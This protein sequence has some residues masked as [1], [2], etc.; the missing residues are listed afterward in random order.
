MIAQARINFSEDDDFQAEQLEFWFIWVNLIECDSIFKNS[1]PLLWFDVDE[2]P[3]VVLAVFAGNSSSV[4][5][6]GLRELLHVIKLL[7]EIK[8]LLRLVEEDLDLLSH[9]DFALSI[10][11]QLHEQTLRILAIDSWFDPSVVVGQFESF[12]VPKPVVIKDWV[13]VVT[14]HYLWQDIGIKVDRI[15]VSVHFSFF[16][17]I[18]DIFLPILLLRIDLILLHKHIAEVPVKL[19][20]TLS[21]SRTCNH[22]RMILVLRRLWDEPSVIFVTSDDMHII[23]VCGHYP[24]IGVL[25]KIIHQIQ[26]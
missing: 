11:I 3:V 22:K 9:D 16:I 8:L 7:V 1:S 14:S 19:F 21:V 13:L 10:V 24:Y 25:S 18:I 5:V 12:A 26:I 6:W 20:Q 2:A 4:D 15:G 23:V 17:K